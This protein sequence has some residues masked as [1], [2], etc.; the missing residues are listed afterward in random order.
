MAMN[1]ETEAFSRTARGRSALVSLA[2]FLRHPTAV[3]SA[4]PATQRMVSHVLDPLDWSR[5]DTFVEYGPGTGE[6]TRGV[7]RRLNDN[8]SLIAIETGEDFVELLRSAISD[9]RL[10][11]VQGGA[12]DVEAILRRLKAGRPDCILSGLPVSTLEPDE[13]EA[14]IGASRAVLHPAGQLVAYQMRRAIEQY[15]HHHFEKV[16]TGF[17]WWN[18][19]PCHLYWASNPSGDGA[20]TWRNDR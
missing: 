1:I 5:I 7:L 13:A 14:I 11:V 17:E 3:G 6:F 8:A 12:Q 15:L 20:T 19:P 2:E 18:V 9:S 4:F 16:E 10:T